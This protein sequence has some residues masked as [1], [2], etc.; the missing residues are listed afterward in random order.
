MEKAAELT[1]INRNKGLDTTSFE[2]KIA[3]ASLKHRQMIEDLFAIAPEDAKPGIV[4][5]LDYPKNVYKEVRDSLRSKNII[6]PEN[7]FNGE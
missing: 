1:G 6:P 2:I 4:K 5:V 3:W 7:P